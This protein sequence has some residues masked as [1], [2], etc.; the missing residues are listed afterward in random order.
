MILPKTSVKNA[1]YNRY[2]SGLKNTQYMGKCPDFK[3]GENYYELEGF[4][5][6][7][8]ENALRNMLKR[9]VRQS[10]KIIIQAEGSTDN[11]IKRII[12]RRIKAGQKIK[13]LWVQETDGSLRRVY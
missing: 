13:E 10:D 6:D 4:T 7:K 5:T 2:F 1:A 9:G 11:H 12:H 8:R 3:V